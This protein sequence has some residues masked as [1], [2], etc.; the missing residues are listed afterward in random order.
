MP[1]RNNL[2]SLQTP[3]NGRW[4]QLHRCLQVL[5]QAEPLCSSFAITALLATTIVISKPMECRCAQTMASSEKTWALP[6]ALS[7]ARSV[8]RDHDL[9]T[10]L[11]STS[12]AELQVMTM[13][14]FLMWF[15][16]QLSLC[17]QL[18]FSGLYKLLHS[19]IGSTAGSAGP[20]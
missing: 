14:L 20:H 13:Q 7:T 6:P 18:S 9:D 10:L 16:H 1:A 3:E 19:D 11:S 5:L 4:Q 12:F 17:C 15:I 8:A 2:Q